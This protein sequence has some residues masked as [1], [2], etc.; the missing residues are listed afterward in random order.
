M[1]RGRRSPAWSG[2][3]GWLDVGRAGQCTPESG[4]KSGGLVALLEYLPPAP[5]PEGLLARIENRLDA[6]ER[7][8]SIAAARSKRA[9]ARWRLLGVG[10]TGALAGAAAMA[11]V[12]LAGPAG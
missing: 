7:A 6:F 4:T 5:P 3:F 11:A 12:L 1:T 9:H 10:L 8:R 2:G